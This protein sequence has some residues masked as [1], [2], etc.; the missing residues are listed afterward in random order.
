M[1]VPMTV[2]NQKTPSDHGMLA[3]LICQPCQINK[4]AIRMN[5]QLP[6]FDGFRGVHEGHCWSS[7]LDAL[8]HRGCGCRGVIGVIVHSSLMTAASNGLSL[9]CYHVGNNNA[10]TIYFSD[11][12]KALA[13]AW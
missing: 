6:W 10:F 9:T 12:I 4:K 7:Q 5:V 1:T 11:L 2:I 3:T 13:W 8:P